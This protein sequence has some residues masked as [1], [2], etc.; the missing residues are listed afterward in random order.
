MSGGFA[1][2][3]KEPTE[4]CPYCT[5][6]CTADFVD[7]GVGYVQCGPYHC[8]SC[9][10]SEIGPN[11]EG[12]KLSKEEERTGWYAPG[13]DP[14]SS[15]NV[16]DGKVVTYRQMEEEYRSEFIGNPAYELPGYVEDWRK[17]IRRK[18]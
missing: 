9:G 13:T 14:G 15:A 18:K 16:I 6:Q 3:D 1:Y 17:E 5:C 7:V 12:R 10:A 4:S 2:G 8:T 11:D